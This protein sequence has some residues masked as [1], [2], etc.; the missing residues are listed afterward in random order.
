MKNLRCAFA[1][2]VN[3]NTDADYLVLK[4]NSSDNNDVRPNLCVRKTWR[5]LQYSIDD[6]TPVNWIDIGYDLELC[7][8][9]YTATPTFVTI[10]M[11]AVGF[12]GDKYREYEFDYWVEKIS[13]ADGSVMERTFT[14]IPETEDTSNP[15]P[16]LFH[17]TTGP[18]PIK[19]GS[20]FTAFLLTDPDVTEPII[21]CTPQS[22]SL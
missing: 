5:G 12:E 21:I 13:L 3:D 16:F 20:T 19:D 18:V 1:E 4:T 11:D 17:G 22:L 14:T 10:D 8:A 6:G 7:V 9:Y 15:N 2:F